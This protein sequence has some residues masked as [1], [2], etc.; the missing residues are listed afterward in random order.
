MTT[1]TMRA[2]ALRGAG[3][4]LLATAGCSVMGADGGEQPGLIQILPSSPAQVSVPQSAPRGEPFTVEVVTHG[5]G[6]LSK[7]PTRVRTGGMSADVRPYDRDSGGDVC[8]ADVALYRHTATLR[9]DQPGTAT[10]RIHGRGEPGRE[11]VTI[12]RTVTIQ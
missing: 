1:A 11:A 2:L 10:V 3:A 5:G 6:C 8:P 4:A 9:F 12:T 7:G